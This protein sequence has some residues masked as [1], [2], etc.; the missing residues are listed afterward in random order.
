LPGP[1]ICEGEQIVA[2]QF[3]PLQGV[4]FPEC[5]ACEVI[6]YFDGAGLPLL[7][8]AKGEKLKK[9]KLLVP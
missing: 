7:S 6:F 1:A 2:G 9:I 4:S 5:G 3:S 8:K